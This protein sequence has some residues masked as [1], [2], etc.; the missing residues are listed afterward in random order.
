[1]KEL[2][3]RANEAGQ[4]LDKFL[5]KYMD[6][7]P[8]GF[9]YK[10]L[11]KKNITLNGK[12]ASGSE[13]LSEGDVVRLFLAE[14]TIGKFSR[15]QKAPVQSSEGRKSAKLDIIYEDKHTLF[16][17][18]PVGM[19]S[20]KAKPEDVSLVE[21]LTAYLLSSGQ[22]KEEE[23]RTFRPSVCNRL[24]RNTSGIVAAGKTLAA[25]QEL[26]EMFRERTLKKYYLC[27]VKGTVTEKKRI[28]GYLVKN[29]KTNTVSIQS[30]KSGGASLI[31]TEYRP[32]AFGG[33]FTLLEVHLITG[34]THQIRAHLASQGHPIAGDTKYGD[35]AVN[36]R[37]KKEY[38][39]K[40]QL[41]HS[42]RLCMP[43][44][45][46]ALAPL[47]GKVITAPVPVLFDKI[48]RGIG[49]SQQGKGSG[50]A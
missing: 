14:E 18:K 34:K 4:R 35:R 38:G 23:L 12:K 22:I 21:H 10:M 29:E 8:K 41:L 9:L 33:G 11:R 6:Q 50:P 30:E 46:G 45:A 28:S 24:D 32:L 44:C 1:M 17:N 37:L 36:E 31:E 5:G 42:A 40:S 47:S 16:I 7:A 43:E 15:I 48:C 20:Q 25:L 27:L 49:L 3:I 13:M 19:L 2:C 39:L 26:T